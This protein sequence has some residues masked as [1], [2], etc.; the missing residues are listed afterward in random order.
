M[1]IKGNLVPRS[2]CKAISSLFWGQK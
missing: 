2:Y 1:T